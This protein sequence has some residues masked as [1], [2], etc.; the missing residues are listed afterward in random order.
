M[1]TQTNQKSAFRKVGPCLYRYKNG[2]YYARF[3]SGGKE[4]RCSLET[5]DRK[6]AERNLAKKKADQ[7]KIDR[8]QGKL[9]LRELC[10]RYGKAIASSKSKTLEQ[11]SGVVTRIKDDWPT[12]SLV[13]WGRSSQA[14][15]ICG[16]RVARAN[17]GR[18]SVLHRAMPMSRFSK[19]CSRWRAVT[20]L[21]SIRLRR[22]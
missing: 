13:K 8:S 9:T 10:D 1:S 21:F 15:A 12:G 2:V 6:L 18:A 4:I 22:I 16:W 17:P 20:E 7:S 5:T 3:K 11:K 14:T 19:K